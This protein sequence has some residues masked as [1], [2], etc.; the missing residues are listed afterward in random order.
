MSDAFEIF[1]VVAP[2]L[3][4]LLAQEAAE[5]GFDVTGT[6]TGGVTLRGGWEDVWRANIVLRGATRVLLRLASF[7]APHLAQLDKRSRRLAW[8]DW[9]PEGSA[10][11]VEATC[12]KSRIYHKRGA[13]ER[14]EGAI[15]AALSAPTDTSNPIAVKLRIED[16]LATISVDTSGEALHRRG[17]KQQVNKAPMRET[18]AAL[19]LR[20]CGYDGSQPVLDPMC[21]SGT[22]VIEAAEIA[23]GLLPG[24]DRDFAFEQLASFDA[25]RV[26]RMRRR[27]APVPQPRFFGSDRDSGAIKMSQTNAERAGVA[28]LATF[29]TR[30]VSELT[31]PCSEPGLV[32]VNPP[33]GARIGNKRPLFGLYGAFGHVLKERFQ[34]WRVGLVTADAGLAKATA[35]PFEPPGPSI[36]HGGIRVRLYQC[37]V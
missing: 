27:L 22:F 23:A 20:A 5:L 35:L 17:H 13:A 34:G 11:T 21:G 32:I 36:D 6:E 24:R 29:E 19:F 7:R 31:P 26:A 15:T 14:V 1:L 16:D 3:E 28:H 9:L 8:A 2:G 30:A 33:Y 25:D 4:P 12:R 10:V 37:Q 18:L